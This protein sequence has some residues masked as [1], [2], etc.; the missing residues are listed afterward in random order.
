MRNDPGH[1]SIIFTLFLTIII[2]L[3]LCNPGFPQKEDPMKKNA[4]TEIPQK[5][6]ETLYIITLALSSP[7]PIPEPYSSKWASTIVKDTGKDAPYF[8]FAAEALSVLN[9]GIPTTWSCVDY[10]EMDMFGGQAREWTLS[11]GDSKIYRDIRCNIRESWSSLE[12][13]ADIMEING[14]PGGQFITWSGDPVGM[15]IGNITEEKKKLILQAAH[16]L[17]KEVSCSEKVAPPHSRLRSDLLMGKKASSAASPQEIEGL[18]YLAHDA[19]EDVAVAALKRLAEYNCLGD[20]EVFKTVTWAIRDG[21]N[22]VRRKAAAIAGE[23]REKKYLP[24]LMKALRDGDSSVE[25]KAADSLRAIGDPSAV[26]ALLGMLRHTIDEPRKMAIIA[27][28]EIATPEQAPTVVAGLIPYLKD[29]SH[30][31]REVTAGTLS[32]YRDKRLIDP[33]IACLKDNY[34][35]VRRDAAKALGEWKEVKAVP[36]L[37]EVLRDEDNWVVVDAVTAL[38]KIGD[39]RAIAPIRELLSRE[40][41]KPDG[42]D[43]DIKLASEEALRKLEKRP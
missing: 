10:T 18:L 23:C 33:F 14:L 30:Y 28:S 41:A 27:I 29:E 21:S 3:S 6:G 32:A 9:D 34:D 40:K 2:A 19:D 4:I 1:R 43:G 42:G 37:I 13:D 39:S 20:P 12:Y 38:A 16:A 25:E 24:V 15:A 11:S 22:P 17:F 5:S 8:I 35:W 7:L 31:V 26:P 36:A